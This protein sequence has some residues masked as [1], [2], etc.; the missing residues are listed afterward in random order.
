M[1]MVKKAGNVDD[2]AKH[3][4]DSTT[5]RMRTVAVLVLMLTMLLLLLLLG[6]TTKPYQ[7]T[8]QLAH[9]DQLLDFSGGSQLFLWGAARLL[10]N[11]PTMPLNIKMEGSVIFLHPLG[12]GER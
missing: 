1:T 11:K 3:Y 10:Q 12:R 9:W 8:E 5:K 2:H 6:T 7:I 4:E